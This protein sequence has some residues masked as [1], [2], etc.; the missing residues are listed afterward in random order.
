MICRSAPLRATFDPS[1]ASDLPRTMRRRAF[2]FA[3]LIPLVAAALFLVL[4]TWTQPPEPRVTSQTEPGAIEVKE[5][6]ENLTSSDK[7]PLS[8][9]AGPREEGPAP[10]TS[11]ISFRSATG[12]AIPGVAI[13]L[14]PKD[15]ALLLRS[16]VD[17]LERV[18]DGGVLRVA[19]RRK[20]D[21]G[22]RQ[23][24]ARAAGYLPADVTT[25]MTSAGAH[26]IV[27]TPGAT[28]RVRCV[29]V[30]GIP[31]VGARVA[32]VGRYG[33]T[34][35]RQGIH[36]EDPNVSESSP[37]VDS[38]KAVYVE[39]SGNGGIAPFLALPNDTLRLSAHKED[40]VCVEG[41]VSVDVSTER[42]AT[43]VFGALYAA[44]VRVEGDLIVGS[45]IRAIDAQGKPAKWTSPAS[46]WKRDRAQKDLMARYPEGEVLVV[47]PPTTDEVFVKFELLLEKS[48]LQ[49][50]TVKATRLAEPPDI[51][52]FSASTLAAASDM[53][54]EVT[55]RLV[56]G[57]GRAVPPFAPLI[58]TF[59]SPTSS[60]GRIPG[61]GFLDAIN[62]RLTLGKKQRLPVGQYTVDSFSST[63]SSRLRTKSFQVLPGEAQAIDLV[64]DGDWMPCRVKVVDEQ[65][66]L[67]ST[68]LTLQMERGATEFLSFDRGVRELWLPVGRG[69]LKSMDPTFAAADRT[70]EVTERSDGSV[71][72]I[73]FEGR[74][75]R[76]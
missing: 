26:T 29:D 67:T 66:A 46:S 13:W 56:D 52:T 31:V 38:G 62:V 55:V 11:E 49:E 64:I 23:L 73:V 22:S 71:Q 53:S 4:R 5:A 70:F 58:C 16:E 1:L 34:L 65:G 14:E 54:T 44:L 17:P 7:D 74:R 25:A 2:T 39:T 69:R 32:L 75:V 60:K 12:E 41:P 43:I 10:E 59:P 47:A 8:T 3:I 15:R 40:L 24:V 72:E 6:S 35:D 57:A 18:G 63:V 9:V 51:T 19:V 50:R 27:L 68:T 28:F 20:E 42:E 61:P 45:R 76:N 36:L 21:L 30:Y 33:S 48:G 37:G